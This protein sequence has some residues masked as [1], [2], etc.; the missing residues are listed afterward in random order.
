MVERKPSPRSPTRSSVEPSK[1]GSRRGEDPA[2]EATGRSP[3]GRASGGEAPASRPGM[4]D[5]G[6]LDAEGLIER[7]GR[8]QFPPTLYLEGPDE[9]LKAAL[10]AELR[11]AWA[12]SCPEA[13][14]AR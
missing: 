9:A 2:A 13:P 5:G 14:A 8:G 1:A 11:A 3:R 4:G 12:A 7:A 10:L 6:M